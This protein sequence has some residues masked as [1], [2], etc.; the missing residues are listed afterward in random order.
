[1]PSRSLV[2]IRESKCR[3]LARIHIIKGRGLF[4]N[5]SHIF[6]GPVRALAPDPFAEEFIGCHHVDL[7]Q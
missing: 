3:Y 2:D 5:F 7:H 1:M 6:G 4:Y